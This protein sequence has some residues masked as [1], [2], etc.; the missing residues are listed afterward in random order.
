[1]ISGYGLF[2]LF[3]LASA[4]KPASIKHD[5]TCALATGK[6]YSIACAET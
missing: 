2:L 4:D 5:L 1:M 6:E 3:W